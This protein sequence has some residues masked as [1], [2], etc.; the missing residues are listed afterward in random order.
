MK[1]SLKGMT[2]SIAGAGKV[3]KTL[4]RLM[5]RAGATIGAVRCRT[6]AHARVSVRFIGAGTPQG[7]VRGGLVFVTVPDD[8]I[9]A[10]IRGLPGT[11]VHCAGGLDA[12]SVGA[13]G[14]FH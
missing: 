13:D 3:G 2:I 8:A 11:R 4:G 10:V 9:T 1:K 14:S 5:R 6:L 12:R 7:E